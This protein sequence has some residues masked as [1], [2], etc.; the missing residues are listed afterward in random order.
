MNFFC[1]NGVPYQSISSE[2]WVYR[3]CCTV[4]PV[5]L[6]T[7]VYIL[8]TPPYRCLHPLYASIQMCTRSVCP[9]TYVYTLFMQSTSLY[10]PMYTMY[11][12]F[13]V[14]LMFLHPP[15]NLYTCV[16]LLYSSYHGFSHF[17]HCVHHLYNYFVPSPEISPRI[18][19]SKYIFEDFLKI[20]LMPNRS[21]YNAALRHF[22]LRKL[23]LYI[24]IKQKKSNIRCKYYIFTA[25]KAFGACLGMEIFRDN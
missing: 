19:T 8:C 7:D 15:Y 14:V 20:F 1:I 13:T 4:R 5:R 11:T 2:K 17:V 10:S 18:M 22:L 21:D 9:R 24:G 3:V 23:T 6:R 12:K 25:P 16:N